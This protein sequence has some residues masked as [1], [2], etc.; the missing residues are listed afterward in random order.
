MTEQNND[1][2]QLRCLVNFSKCPATRWLPMFPELETK[3]VSIIV[4]QYPARLAVS[5]V[6]IHVQT[7]L[8]Q[9]S[10]RPLVTAS[11]PH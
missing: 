1:I 7:K 10:W 4:Q 6:S 3:L 11:E 2:D 8:T 9:S 5:A